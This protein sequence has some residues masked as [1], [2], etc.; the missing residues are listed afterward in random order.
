MKPNFTH[1]QIK[2]LI[3]QKSVYIYAAN[4]EGLGICRL[5]TR[6]GIDVQGFIDSRKYDNNKKK[7]KPIIHPDTFFSRN[8]VSQTFIIIATKHRKTKRHAIKQCKKS[9]LVRNVSYIVITDLCEFLPTIEVV[10][11]CNLKCISCEV[12]APDIKQIGLMSPETYREVLLK[13]T[14]EIPFMNSVCLYEWGEPFLHPQLPEII[15]ITSEFGL[16]SDIS[17]NLNYGKHIEEI[18]KAE[19]DMLTI[20]C[21]GIG[22]NYE[23]T[24]TKGKW[25]IFKKNL[26]SLRN[27]IDKY[28]SD[29]AVRIPYH[30]YKH[31]LKKDYDYVEALV[32][33]LGFYFFPILANIFPGKVYDYVINNQPLPMGMQKANEM[34]IIPMEEQLEYAYEHREL[35]CPVMKAFPSVR[36][37]KSVLHCCNMVKPIV[38]N[39][40]LEVSLEQ[41]MQLRKDADTCGKCMEKG[42]HR[43]FD[44]NATVEVINGK[45][46]VRRK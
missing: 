27:Y 32:Q 9:G 22:K 43:F 2:H 31:N 12:G 35:F 11:S 15:R 8:D 7:D 33:E 29:T 46:V 4:L 23:I 38:H 30:M 16:T 40:Y 13:M 24:H 44:V 42:L 41:L 25:E 26:Y 21:S 14:K 34:L 10:G 39:D 17:S 28:K 3:G 5:F 18:V 1:E 36:S 6:L 19:P 45:R 37:D 20:P